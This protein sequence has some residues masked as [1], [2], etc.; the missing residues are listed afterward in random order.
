MAEAAAATRIRHPNQEKASSQATRLVITL[1]LLV[2]AVLIAV[3]LFGGWTANQGARWLTI[4]YVIIY[5][6]MAYYIFRWKRGVLML[7]AALSLLFV[8]YSAI[9]LPAWFERTKEGYAET[10]LP[11]GLIG[12]LIVVIIIIQSFTV[13]ASMVGF[14][15]AWN[16]EVEERTGEGDEGYEDDEGYGEDDDY[17]GDDDE[18]ADG[19][20]GGGE[21]SREEEETGEHEPAGD[22]GAAGGAG[23]G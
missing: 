11:A 14:N 7:A 22:S 12:L 4:A 23:R 10:W 9:G 3:V 13:V 6:V 5:A 21:D 17:G 18:P 8:I 20:D 15:Q 19:P 2:S 16:V 1:L